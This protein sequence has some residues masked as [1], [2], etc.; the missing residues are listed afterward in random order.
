[1]GWITDPVGGVPALWHD[2]EDLH[3]HA[4][5]LI[6]P[7]THWGVI[8]LV[9]ANTFIPL[10][11]AN[12]ALTSLDAGVTRLLVGQTP[13]ASTSLTTFYLILDG[14]LAVLLALA[15]WPLLRLRRWSRKFGQRLRQRPQ[16]LR[17]GLRLAWEVALPV[18]L[19]LGVSLL[20][21]ELGATSWD[22][23][24]LAWPDLGSWV[25]AIC[26]VLLLTGVIRA[27]LA[28]RVIRRKAAETSPVTPSPSPSLM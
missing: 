2:G 16:F 9:N 5:M 14:V 15:L 24:L 28:V 11:G 26:A 19:L 23:I 25:L 22:W 12:T 8:L 10:D 18:A 1:M 21:S 3:F 4:L 6:E 27:V 20:A 7:Q 13:Q 17:L